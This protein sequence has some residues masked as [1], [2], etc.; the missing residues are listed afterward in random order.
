[1]PTSRREVLAVISG[2][3]TLG[4]LA[5]CLNVEENTDEE[6]PA[7][8]PE[9]TETDT[10]AG[11]GGSI[12][13]WYDI[14]PAE[15]ELYSG[16]LQQFNEQSKHTANGSNVSDIEKKV[17]NAIPAGQGPETFY[18]AHDRMGQYYKGDFLAAH[19]DLD[20]DLESLFTPVA[21]EAVQFDGEVLA[22]PFAAE[23]VGL[24]YNTD[25]VDSPPETVSEMVSVM[26]EHHDPDNGEYGL[27]YPLSS[28]YRTSAWAHAF[29][30]YYYDP[31]KPEGEKLGLTMDETIQGFQYI[32]ENFLPY[33]ATD[34][35]G[36]AQNAVFAEGR[37]PFC[38]NGPW[39]VAGF[40]DGGISLDVTKLPKPEGGSPSPY[41]GVRI[42]YFT[43]ETKED[44][45]AT[46]ATRS[47]VKWMTTT[48]EIP[49]KFANEIGVIPVL[50]DLTGSDELP[51]IVAG[52]SKAVEQ[53]T[54]MPATPEMS[55]VWDPTIEAFNKM[56]A[57][58]DADPKPYME[59]AEESIRSNWESS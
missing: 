15:Q 49:L 20:I 56:V 11:E 38:I 36:D 13:V 32:L 33:M 17:I 22:L 50:Q 40:S 54:L 8:Q 7:D 27:A 57:N 41:T 10:G 46:D 19:N 55:A 35:S 37:A 59:S 1:M 6:S 34:L 23:T 3:T 53:G 42:W 45:A 58:P 52:Y 18:W 9:G 2:V 31:T 28:A 26:E 14:E 39:S 47:F 29:G 51:D 48:R 21:V 5:G 30:G 44:D 16:T 43:K 25:L 4:P 12:D 24:I